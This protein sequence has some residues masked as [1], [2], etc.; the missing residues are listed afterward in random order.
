MKINKSFLS[1][2][3]KEEIKRVL[4]E[5]DPSWTTDAINLFMDIRDRS[6]AANPDYDTKE[7]FVKEIEDLTGQDAG[8][9]FSYLR[10]KIDKQLYVHVAQLLNNVVDIDLL[11]DEDL[12]SPSYKS[13]N[14]TRSEIDDIRSPYKTDAPS[15][16]NRKPQPISPQRQEDPRGNK[17]NWVH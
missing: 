7:N 4:Y 15:T 3:I 14:P 8:K 12:M 2:I 16:Y 11:G 6:I 1:R 13:K 9:V 5:D 10:G 17:K